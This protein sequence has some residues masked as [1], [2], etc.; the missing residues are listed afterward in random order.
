MLP[1]MTVA[2]GHLTAAEHPPAATN[3][4]ITLVVPP[5]GH[6]ERNP[7]A[8]AAGPP[9]RCITLHYLLP[10]VMMSAVSALV[11]IKNFTSFV[12]NG[13]CLSISISL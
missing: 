2:K 1:S 4:S 13:I 3:Q 5:V 10:C 7:G 12:S 6:P 11:V 9:P 8:W